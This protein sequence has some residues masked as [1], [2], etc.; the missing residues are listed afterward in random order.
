MRQDTP[1]L[2]CQSAWA[3]RKIIEIGITRLLGEFK[4][5]FRLLDVPHV[6]KGSCVIDGQAS[7][8]QGPFNLKRKE[9][10][11]RRKKTAEDKKSA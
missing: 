2:R 11:A 10:P 3:A 4:G 9:R 5:P 8:M 1:Q 6:Q 7:M